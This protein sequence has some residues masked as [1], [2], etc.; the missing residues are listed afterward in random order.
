MKILVFGDI[1][2]RTIWKQIIEDTNP[3]LTI[4]L[5]DYVTTHENISPE[6]QLSNLYDILDYKE[7]NSNSVILLRGNHDMCEL[8]Y[9]W[10]ECWP[11]ERKVRDIM[12]VDPLKSRFLSLTQWIYIMDN[13]VFSHAGIS[14][15]WLEHV[16]GEIDIH[17]INNY[18][19]SERFGFYPENYYD[20]S[21]QSQTQPPTWIGPLT[22]VTCNIDGYTQ[23]VGH[24]PVKV[25]SCIYAENGE[26]IWLCDNLGN[27][28][29]LIIEDNKFKRY[30]QNSR[31]NS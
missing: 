24:T 25:V 13:I 26:H 31:S 17:N 22:L 9:Y 19:I 20:Y 21:G 18:E 3:D 5:G 12:S 15:V 28:E 1:H 23:V 6:Q 16:L 11:S 4:F 10:A 7:E 2:G 29:C 30:E 14:K 8:G 27:G